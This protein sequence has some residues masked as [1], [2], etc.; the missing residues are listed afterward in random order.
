M[1]GV[2]NQFRV[3]II[4]GGYGGLTVA[5][6]L[7]SKTKNITVTIVDPKDGQFA[8]VAA[9]RAL[10]NA[11]M[12]QSAFLPYA[13]MSVLTG[14]RFRHVQ[15]YA[16]GVDAQKRVVAL[17]GTD[18][19]VAYDALIIA[20]GMRYA[21]P[22]RFDEGE[23]R[24]TTTDLRN[25]LERH[26]KAIAAADDIIVV[27]GGATGV[28]TAAEIKEAFPLKKV[29]IYERNDRLLSKELSAKDSEA[30]LNAVQ[31]RGIVVNLNQSWDRQID[32]T[33]G[34]IVVI[35]AIGAR[36]NTSFLNSSWLDERGFIRT[37]SQLAI[38][39]TSNVFA[40]G[41]VVRG[42][43]K[44]V[45]VATMQHAPVLAKNI[46]AISK[47]KI[48]TAQVKPLPGMMNFTI[49]TLGTHDAFATGLF[50][51]MF[52]KKKEEDLFVSM[53]RKTYGITV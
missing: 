34:R 29:A 1:E 33:D 6:T 42:Y 36:P 11:Q 20:P 15:A 53:Q 39:G 17:Q 40:L 25:R 24:T 51:K 13:Q 43:A 30:L 35:Q 22:F 49:V 18:Q 52:K 45:K 3:V 8:S 21:E 28:E 48:A 47:G 9:P 7:L 27:G 16:A 4:G 5:K 10:V 12:A 46:I 37:D 41:D 19:I 38:V 14:P 32:T 50:G 26:R 2:A 31:A 23:E 44:N